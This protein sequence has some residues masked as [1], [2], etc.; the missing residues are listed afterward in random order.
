MSN[1]PT[2]PTTAAQRL[3]A[4]A[5]GA[6][7]VTM[8]KFNSGNWSI[9]DIPVPADTKFV[10]YPDQVI[11]AW[12]HFAG[13][14]VVPGGEI[15]ALVAEDEDGDTE[16][17]IVKGQAR[18]DLGDLDQAAWEL[19]K[20]SGK[21]RDPWNYSFGL[22]MMNTG[23]GAVVMY[24]ASSV[25]GMGAIG[26]LVGNYNRNEH[27]GHPVVKLS[28]NSYKNKKYGG[29]TAFPVFNVVGYDS[30]PP[31]HHPGGSPPPVHN[32]GEAARVIGSS[33]AGNNDMDD[34]I[35]F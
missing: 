30:P 12:T 27:L 3:D 24:K 29:F 32:P 28:T 22:P 14:K 8:L 34:D 4:L 7:N 21:P 2:K 35:P 17:R 31:I 10:V 23:T 15:T 25:G 18:E 13:G 9:A 5:R 19:D 26:G 11:H 33:K 16:Q 1:L 20:S 6:S